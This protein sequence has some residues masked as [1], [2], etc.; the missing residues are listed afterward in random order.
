MPP[1]VLELPPRR[2]VARSFYRR[3]SWRRQIIRS[4][5]RLLILAL[6]VLLL[7]GGW[8]LANKGFGRQWRTT[9]ADELRKRGVEASVRKLTL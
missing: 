4:G 1:S 9:V 6:I 8:Y 2:K 3:W 5:T 7:L